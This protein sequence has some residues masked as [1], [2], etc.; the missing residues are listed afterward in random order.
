ML[1]AAKE[2]DIQKACLEW[3]HY[4]G[5]FAWRSNQVPVPLKG[6]GFRRFVGLRGVSDILGILPQR[7]SCAL[8]GVFLAVE[9]K[10]PRTGRLSPEQ[11][12]FL[13]KVNDL[14]GLGIVVTSVEDLEEQLQPHLF[15]ER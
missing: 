13:A 4:Q 6:G 5:I 1:V 7:C 3:L 15:E 12:A 9:V 8:Q 10:R 11:K 2:S 14:G